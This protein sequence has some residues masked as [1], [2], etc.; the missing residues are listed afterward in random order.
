MSRSYRRP[1]V[2]DRNP[3]AK[4]QANRAIRRAREVPCG[5]VYKKFYNPYNICDH[6]WYAPEGPRDYVRKDGIWVTLYPKPWKYRRK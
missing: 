2:K 4:N 1:Y 5:K 6:C 3:Y